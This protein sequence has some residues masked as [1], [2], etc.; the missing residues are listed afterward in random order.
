MD[1]YSLR[2]VARI[3]KVS[4]ARLRYWERTD[5]VKSLAKVESRA[6]FEFRD[7]VCLRGILSLL[8]QGV[9]LRRIRRNVEI[10]RERLPEMDDPLGSLRLWA[11]GSERVVIRHEG[12][13]MEPDGQA[14]LEF[15]SL[16][17]TELPVTEIGGGQVTSNLESAEE[18]FARGCR[19]DSDAET[20]AEAIA[21][22]LEGIRLV[23]DFADCHC[24][25]GAVYY[26]QGNRDFARAS[27][28]RCLEIEARHVEANF[29]LAN[30]LE[31]EGDDEGALRHYRSAFAADPLY[32]DLH[33]NMALLYEKMGRVEQGR[34]H[35][36]RY[37]QLD[38]SGPWAEV[39]RRRLEQSKTSDD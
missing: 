32:P 33:I 26:N 30:L 8:E 10:L 7:L 21:C 6:E 20:F 37:L 19:L 11:E 36:R 3:L 29:N 13:L 38:D 17:V 28:V 9:P 2:D 14:V 15:G 31:E 16:A 18:C 22:Y 24:N 25:L 39:A 27:F 34:R 23:P 12:V 4:P 35:W 5:L 1:T